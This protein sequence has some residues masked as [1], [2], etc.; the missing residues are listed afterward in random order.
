MIKPMKRT[1]YIMDW[2]GF[3]AYL[4]HLLKTTV[5]IS[6]DG[7]YDM[8]Y[9]ADGGSD[10]DDEGNLTELLELIGKDLGVML[11]GCQAGDDY[12]WLLVREGC[13]V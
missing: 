7:C 1:V 10:G 9:T 8:R 5:I 11:E 2:D 13:N 3:E 6:N 4:S 12:V